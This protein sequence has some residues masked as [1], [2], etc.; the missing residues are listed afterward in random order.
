MKVPVRKVTI[1]AGQTWVDSAVWCETP[2]VYKVITA[3]TRGWPTVITAASH[4]IPAGVQIPVWVAN[5]E[6]PFINTTEEK[7]WIAERADDNTLTLLGVNTG[8]QDSYTASSATLSYVP[9]KTLTGFTARMQF[10][11]TITGAVLV[12]A[13]STGG[14]PEVVI[15]AAIGKITTTLTPAQTR[16]LLAGGS[17]ATSGICHVELIDSNGLV[18]RPWD[19]AW[20]ATPEG[21][22][23][24]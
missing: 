18:Y 9:P 21:T 7:P 11:R 20:T 3:V 8:G 5:A 4:G 15:T 12:E 10:R 24:S 1:A 17:V 14:D 6:G 13:V 2:Y 23:E 16:A 22:R 19:Y